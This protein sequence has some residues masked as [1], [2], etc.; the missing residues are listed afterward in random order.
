MIRIIAYAWHHR[1]FAVVTLLAA[2][3]CTAGEPPAGAVTSEEATFR[4][5]TVAEGLNQPW[6]LA[7]LPDGDR[8]VTERGG[9]L[10]RLSDGEARTIEGVPEVATVNQGGLLDVAL[11]PD[12]ADNRWIYLSYAAAGDGGYATRLGRA[13][14]DDDRLA[15]F[16][17][18]FTAEPYVRGGRHFGSRIVFRDGYLFL[19][20]GDRGNREHAQDLDKYHGKLI[21]LTL[22]GGIPPDNPFVDQSSARP[23]IYSYGHRNPQGMIVHPDTGDIWLHEHGPQG[24]DEV[25]RIRAGANYGW[26]L[27]T[28]GENYGGGRFAPEPPL[29]GTVSPVHHWTPSIAPSGLAIYQGDAFPTWRGDLFAGA[30][31]LTHLA[32][33]ELEAG[34]VMGEERLLDDAGMRIRD[35]RSGPDGYLYLLTDGSNGKLLRL[36]PAD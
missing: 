32:R 13:R 35:V 6:S 1:R 14:L 19:T 8:L 11:H 4:V 29:E 27:A 3:A 12:F 21:R 18:L 34:E 24:G 9:R 30:L 16:E 5:E 23:G 15:D 7:F 33:L 31:K 2:S 28:F 36:A 20:A 22:D 10:L 26:P 25:N 17:V